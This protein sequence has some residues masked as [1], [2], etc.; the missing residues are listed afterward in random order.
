MKV[1]PYNTGYKSSSVVVVMP[2]HTERRKEL[3]HLFI[4]AIYGPA[5]AGRRID[6]FN[7]GK[8]RLIQAIPP[9]V[10]QCLEHER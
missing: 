10:H 1:R 3:I 8:S 2:V 7:V 4:Y 6:S 9:H 5:A